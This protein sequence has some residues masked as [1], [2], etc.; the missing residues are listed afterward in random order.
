M[1]ERARRAQEIKPRLRHAIMTEWR[2]HGF[3]PCYASVQL[4]GDP[5]FHLSDMMRYVFSRTDPFLRVATMLCW[6]FRVQ[7]WFSRPTKDGVSFEVPTQHPRIL[8]F[9]T[10][11]TDFYFYGAIRRMLDEPLD[12][13]ER[14]TWEHVLFEMVS[15]ALKNQISLTIDGEEFKTFQFF[16]KSELQ[17]DPNS[18]GGRFLRWSGMAQIDTD[19]DDTFVLLEMF[20]DFLMFLQTETC[21]INAADRQRLCAEIEAVLD[22]P[23]WKLARFYQFRTNGIAKPLVN[24]SDVDSLGGVST[25]FAYAPVDAPD[26]VVNI[27]VLRALLINR[28]RWRLFENQQALDVAR[29]IVDFLRRNVQNGVYR[30]SRGYSF[31][32]TEFFCA[33]FGRLWQVCWSLDETQR[34]ALDPHDALS[35]IRDAV[36]AYLADELNP[37]TKRINPLD[38]ALALSIALQIDQADPALLDGCLHVLRERLNAGAYPYH[39]YEIFKGKIPTHMVYGSEATTAALAHDAI[40]LLETTESELSV[41]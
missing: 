31:Y 28:K 21:S 39:A 32:I 15:I 26:L 41:V 27:N 36:V 11:F 40:A 35:V 38:A 2:A 30:T 23:Y 1:N 6:P 10:F 4:R 25:W 7:R 13:D 18:S 14:R 3:F 33:M 16:P 17:L 22:R 8:R 24:Y 9:H 37:N 12:A 34:R 19:A 5:T 20:S 29:G